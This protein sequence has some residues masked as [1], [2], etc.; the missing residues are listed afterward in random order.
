MFGT[1]GLAKMPSPCC[2]TS[3]LVRLIELGRIHPGRVDPE[4]D[5]EAG[6][7][8]HGHGQPH[9]GSHLGGPSLRYPLLEQKGLHI[10]HFASK[11]PE[12]RGGTE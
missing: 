5:V 9:A 4:E 3:G 10:C 12:Q 2:T 11:N 7:V 8:E 1:A 6:Q